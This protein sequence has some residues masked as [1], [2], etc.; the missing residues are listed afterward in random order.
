MTL[1]PDEYLEN[2][3]QLQSIYKNRLPKDIVLTKGICLAAVKQDGDALKYVPETLRDKIR[4][5][6]FGFGIR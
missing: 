3:K 1:T 2:Y 6:V 5:E 4:Q